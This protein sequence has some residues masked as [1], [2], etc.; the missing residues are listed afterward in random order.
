MKTHLF[1]LG[2]IIRT[3]QFGMVTIVKVHLF[4]GAAS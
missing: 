1:G 4:P 2:T 3:C